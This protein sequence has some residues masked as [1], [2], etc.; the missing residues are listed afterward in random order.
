VPPPGDIVELARLRFGEREELLHG[1]HWHRRVNHESEAADRRR[2]DR[3]K[4]LCRIVWDVRLQ[5]GVGH[6]RARRHQQRI[7]IRRRLRDDFG[8]DVAA[9]AGTIFDDDG[10]LQPVAQLLTDHCASTSIPVPAV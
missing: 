8:P 1:A 9:R 3:R 6:M 2:S 10:D 5:R 7:S 4:A